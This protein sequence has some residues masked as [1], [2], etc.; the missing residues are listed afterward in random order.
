MGTEGFGLLA[1]KQ[2]TKP[3]LS[4][5]NTP[6]ELSKELPEKSSEGLSQ[7]DMGSDPASAFGSHRKIIHFTRGGL[8]SL[9]F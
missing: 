1:L 8:W 2:M 7:T 9:L 5:A 3:D 4:P 6:R